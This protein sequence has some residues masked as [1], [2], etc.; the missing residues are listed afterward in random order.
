MRRGEMMIEA[1]FISN[2]VK[3]IKGFGKRGSEKNEK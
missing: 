3:E 2:G 1:V